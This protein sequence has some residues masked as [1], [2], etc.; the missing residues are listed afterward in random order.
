MVFPI[1]AEYGGQVLANLQCEVWEPQVGCASSRL[2]GR[3]NF[4][5]DPQQDYKYF[6]YTPLNGS[7]A[8]MDSIFA[9][10]PD[11]GFSIPSQEFIQSTQGSSWFV[12]EPDFYENDR[13]IFLNK[14][15]KVGYKYYVDSNTLYFKMNHISI[16]DQGQYREAAKPDSPNSP[17]CHVSYSYNDVKQIQISV[18]YLSQCRFRDAGTGDWGQKEPAYMLYIQGRT[19]G[20]SALGPAY[21]I[22]LAEKV[23]E[24]SDGSDIEDGY[25]KTD[26]NKKGGKGSGSIV[27]AQNAE[28][29]NITARNSLF[30]YGS[31]NGD[32]LTYYYMDESLLPALL[33]KVYIKG[34]YNDMSYVRS[35][36]ISAVQVPALGWTLNSGDYNIRV[37]NVDTGVSAKTIK[38][39]FAKKST[40]RKTFD[41]IDGTGTFLDFT[42]LGMRLILPFVGSVN[43]DPNYFFGP[44]GWIEVEASVDCY[45]GNIVYWVYGSSSNNISGT[46]TLYGVY[47]GNC[48]VKV[49]LAGAGVDGSTL[50]DVKNV[51]GTIATGLSSIIGGTMSGNVAGAIAGGAA[52]GINLIGDLININH[53]TYSVD[54]AGTIDTNSTTLCPWQIAIEFDIPTVLYSEKFE[55]MFGIKSIDADNNINNLP[56][57]IYFFD[58][59]KVDSITG[60]SEAEKNKIRELLRSGVFKK[61]SGS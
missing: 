3:I 43:L 31:A 52:S 54:K 19:T 6:N 56:A 40:T 28:R 7:T 33:K 53:P 22:L 24:Y 59:I 41:E 12:P 11:L 23:F 48:G 5:E 57:G 18:F 2:Y 51:S 38:D 39:R 32:G 8:S 49:P 35:A 15:I 34:D 30:S 21:I 1:Y 58:G 29:I 13:E 27:G 4:A 45:T 60:A 25:N 47:S 17:W 20:G 46:D 9:R 50:Q 44:G 14:G 55:E 10:R 16:R 26:T 61:G 37:A 42:G 36:L